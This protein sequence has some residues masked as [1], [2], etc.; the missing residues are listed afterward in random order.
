MRNKILGAIL[1]A[2]LVSCAPPAAAGEWTTLTLPNNAIVY[3]MDIQGDTIW[4][5]THRSGLL[6]Y[7][8]DLWVVHLSA[9][10]GI[11]TNNYNYTVQV[12]SNGDKWVGR[13]DADAVDRLDDAGTYTD[14]TDDIWTYYDY[15]EELE[16]RRVFS[17]VEAP[18]GGMWFGMRDE[19]HNRLG[20]VELLIEND[21]TTT[22]DDVWYHYDNAWTPDSTDFSDD[23]VRALAID[24]PGRLWIG[25]YATGVDAWD[26][27]NP[28]LYADDSIVHYSSD[29]GLPSNLVHTLHVGDDGRVWVG[30]LGGL[31][32]YDGRTDSWRTIEGLPGL[33]ARAIDTDALGHV[34]VGTENG[35]A[36]VYGNG[37]VAVTYGTE[38]GIPND[39]ISE[40]AVDR[41]NGV[42]W[43]VSVDE[44]TQA[45][46]LS[47]LES[48]YGSSMT[49]VF[50]YP[51]PWKEGRDAPEI[52]VFGAPEGA[53]VTVIDV[54]G[55][56]LRKLRSTEPYVWDTLNGAGNEVSSGIYVV[57]VE[58]PEGEVLFTKVAVIR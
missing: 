39:L 20:T 54:S 11:R 40:I 31:A 3:D 55:Q 17:M 37:S 30:T 32:V 45:T 27:G 12:D 36:M 51:N 16:N 29:N 48:G 42:V 4:M 28:A 7:D 2:V 1:M 57:R 52:T 18:Q 8:G 5:S 58:T 19:N 25:Y 14:K 26:Y 41:E 21:D 46:S 13:D 34:W 53:D 6:G 33:Q 47:F 44:A 10:G 22:D 38:D 43:A 23:D 9:E 24:D 35:V 56:E 15:Q 49:N 50:A